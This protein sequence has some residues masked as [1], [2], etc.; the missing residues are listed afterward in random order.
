MLE[1]G[2]FMFK[3][4]KKQVS[5]YMKNW[6]VCF[7]CVKLLFLSKKHK[8]QIDGGDVMNHDTLVSPTQAAVIG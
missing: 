5:K 8:L 4:F 3:V 7:Y 6:K 2:T 1:K